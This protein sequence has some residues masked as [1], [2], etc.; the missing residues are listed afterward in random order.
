MAVPNRNILLFG[1][2]RGRNQPLPTISANNKSSFSPAT[3]D[4]RLGYIMHLW[5][6]ETR[7]LYRFAALRIDSDRLYSEASSRRLAA[8]VPIYPLPSAD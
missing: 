6:N 8:W 5:Q 2:E 1:T 7:L 3:S 4:N